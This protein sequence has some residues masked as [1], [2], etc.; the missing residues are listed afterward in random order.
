MDND[1]KKLRDDFTFS[2]ENL[3]HNLL[4]HCL[5]KSSL[6]IFMMSLKNIV[7]HN[8]EPIVL[9]KFMNMICKVGFRFAKY[10]ET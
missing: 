3:L 7:N 6:Y 8:N 2:Y 10:R 4:Y 1:L 5:D 9:Y